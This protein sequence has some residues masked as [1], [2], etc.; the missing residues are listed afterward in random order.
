MHWWLSKVPCQFISS[1][2]DLA[3][4]FATGSLPMNQTNFANPF[5]HH[6]A[7]SCV[8]H[9]VMAKCQ[10]ETEAKDQGEIIA[11]CK[12]E[13]EA[14]CHCQTHHKNETEDVTHKW[15]HGVIQT[16][17]T[18]TRHFSSAHPW[19]V[20]LLEKCRRHGPGRIP[21]SQSPHPIQVP[22]K[23]SST[24]WTRMTAYDTKWDGKK[25]LVFSVI[26]DLIW[27]KNLLKSQGG[28]TGWKI[29]KLCGKNPT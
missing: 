4:S 3:A 5:L 17:C 20:H 25:R 28:P 7:H 1:T 26:L 23:Y 2:A 14:K 9:A 18:L 16:R 6:S 8:E 11:K 12:H 24:A 10:R 13:T 22:C 29:L 27:C 21:R 19:N 15:R